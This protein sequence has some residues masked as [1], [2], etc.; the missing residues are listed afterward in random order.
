MG[1]RR[2]RV[3]RQGVNG[4]AAAVDNLTSAPRTV[5]PVGGPGA[6]GGELPS[7][8]PTVQEVLS[9]PA[10]AA[11]GPV[12]CAGRGGLARRVRWTHSA[13]VTD[14][15]RLLRG[16]ELLLTTG[17]L[18]PT[19]ADGLRTYVSDLAA[20]GAVG[21]V[22]EAG[23]RFDHVPQPLCEAADEH[24]LP[25]VELVNEVR[26][27]HVAEQVAARILDQQLTDLRASERLHE[28]FTD[29]T[30]EG[31]P[32]TEVVRQVARIAGRPVVL[33][34]LAHQVLAYDAAGTDPA[35]LLAN[36]EGRSRRVLVPERT[37]QD[38]GTGWL[39]TMVGARGR[40]WGRLVLA[41]SERRDHDAVLLERAA[42]TIALSRLVERDR[43]SLERQTH[44]TLLQDVLTGA[45]SATD[46]LLRAR[47][48]GVELERR[49]LV[50]IVFRLTAPPPGPVLVAQERV[51]DFTEDV[52]GAVRDANGSA[53]VGSLDDSTVAALLSLP[54]RVDVDPVLDRVSAALR[55]RTP[56]AAEA[57]AS[58]GWVMAVGSVV[59]A[60]RDVRRSFL[61]A[62]QVADAV[63]AG[64][65]SQ[66]YR[67]PDV[68]LRG[69]LHLLKDDARLQTYVE[70][71]VG[72]LLAHDA[73]T[74][75]GG[76]LVPVLRTYLEVGRNKSAAASAAHLSR[77]SLYERLDRVEQ[78]LG[79]DLDDVETCLSL[80]V[81]LLALD[82]LRRTPG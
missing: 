36:W 46:V 50:A 82:A 25:L 17:V 71:E 54:V 7:A 42:A 13:E 10:V 15:A 14:V 4:C 75:S 16:G 35:A 65:G 57:D 32:T 5:R 72:P 45:A 8:H 41:A 74:R 51:R 6:P 33:E 56:G 12:V 24:G 63:P 23:R 67:L 29:L 20:A 1:R 69:L 81:A 47:V 52:A 9:L 73:A 28:T 79:V 62:A 58:P 37:G 26:F 44:R 68:R 22:V 76:E 39:V 55:R 2:P 18:L 3:G 70:R 19:D 31:A 48:L 21:L 64:G 53:V 80:H 11:G 61:E 59:A 78:V 27:A 66:Y 34:N 60:P 30:V 43:E 77:P 40:D 49:A 38:G